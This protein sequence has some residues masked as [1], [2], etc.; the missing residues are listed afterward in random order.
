MGV[1]V[2]DIVPKW[3]LHPHKQEV[4]CSLGMDKGDSLQILITCPFSGHGIC[5]RCCNAF[6]DLG[7]WYHETS[8][9]GDILWDW[10]K[11]YGEHILRQQGSLRN[12]ILYILRMA[13]HASVYNLSTALRLVGHQWT[14]LKHLDSMGMTA[15][16]QAYMDCV[17][18]W[19]L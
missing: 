14:G 4:R 12:H 6:L 18:P 13:L 9:I 16:T 8:K 2:A 1:V 5:V 3:R 11:L 7:S 10:S 15:L 19:L 17:L